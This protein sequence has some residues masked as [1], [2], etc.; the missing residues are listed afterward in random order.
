VKLLLHA[1]CAPCSTVVLE[2]LTAD[3][4]VFGG[5]GE[6][7]LFYC[8]P[9]I[10][11]QGEYYKRLGEL[12]RFVSGLTPPDGVRL[13]EP[14]APEYSHAEF[15]QAVS[16]L[17]NEPEGG[18]RC[19]K[20]FELRLRK[21]AQAARDGGFDAFATTLTVGSRKRSAD[22]NAVGEAAAQEYGVRYLAEDFKK[23]GGFQRSVEL[24][25]EHSLYRQGYCGCEFAL[26]PSRDTT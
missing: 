2:R 5:G 18:A 8:N 16:G 13:T 6:L 21:T 20:C 23:R 22:I 4:N 11:P 24:S 1:C 14:V 12:R 17:E 9:N 19:I 25:R 10:F 26:P 3:R 15:L 7:A